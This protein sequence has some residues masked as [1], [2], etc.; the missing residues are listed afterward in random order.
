MIQVSVKNI[1]RASIHQNK[2]YFFVPFFLV[3]TNLLPRGE[4]RETKAGYMQD[5]ETCCKTSYEKAIFL[6]IYLLLYT[7]SFHSQNEYSFRNG[8][9]PG[10]KNH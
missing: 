10:W 6:V 9:I 5:A 8:S 7:S 2:K 3:C 4:S 1:K